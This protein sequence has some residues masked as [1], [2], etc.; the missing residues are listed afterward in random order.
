[1][2]SEDREP[3]V[4][5]R[6]RSV[7]S[8]DEVYASGGT[9]PDDLAD[10]GPETQATVVRAAG[11]R[12]V[13]SPFE[14]YGP[15]DPRSALGGIERWAVDAIFAGDEDRYT[16]VGDVTA[17]PVWYGPSRGSM[18]MSIGIGLLPQYRGCGIGTQAQLL[19]ARLL[20]ERGIVRVEAS[21]DVT[22]IAEQRAL[23]KAGFTF[24][25]VARSAQERRDGRHDLQVYSSIRAST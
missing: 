15:V 24:E 17:K 11:H 10:G 14:D 4:Q 1:M 6:L 9:R 18:A 12:E 5:V 3:A 22:N 8:V 2:T 25:G 21:T 7:A 13:T 16:P 20:H 19:L 23:V